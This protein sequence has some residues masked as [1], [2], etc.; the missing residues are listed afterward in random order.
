M[1]IADID[2]GFLNGDINC[3]NTKGVNYTDVFRELGIIAESYG[4]IPYNYGTY[5]YVRF[6]LDKLKEYDPKGVDEYYKLHKK[7]K[8]IYKENPFNITNLDNCFS[9]T[10]YHDKYCYDWEQEAK[11][12]HV[13]YGDGHC[14]DK[15]FHDYL[16][17]NNHDLNSKLTYDSE[18]G[19]FC[20]YCKNKKDANTVATILSSLYNN[21]D[22]M[23][24]LIKET[25]KK[26]DMHFGM[27]MYI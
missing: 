9:V 7:D 21:E 2:E 19:M 6:D 23:I 13:R 1:P 10:L 15:L 14:Y 18:N 24:E 3:I 8:D 11:I 5:E 17:K 27:D 12:N 4:F 26:Y 20:V 22:K 25:K 16:E